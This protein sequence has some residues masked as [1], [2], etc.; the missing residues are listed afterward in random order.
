M[1]D[2]KLPLTRTR[3][4]LIADE[5][6][7]NPTV[8]KAAAVRA[9]GYT[10]NTAAKSALKILSTQTVKA[11]LRARFGH[12]RWPIALEARMMEIINGTGGRKGKDSDAIAAGKLWLD[13]MKVITQQEGG[14]APHVM[15]P[16]ERKAEYKRAAKEFFK[17]QPPG[18]IDVTPGEE[19]K[20]K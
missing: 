7:R 13:I 1:D 12:E 8:G 20:T 18:P 10:N 3:A 15:T 6:E 11:E 17:A 4:Q 14:D 5:L 16:E 9:G 19:K 2:P